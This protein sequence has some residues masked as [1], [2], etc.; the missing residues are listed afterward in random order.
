MA[1]AVS[2]E[3]LLSVL[4]CLSDSELLTRKSY[5][6]RLGA[7]IQIYFEYASCAVPMLF[8]E[9]GCMHLISII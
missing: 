8:T 2:P 3:D 4:T 1:A 9:S 6:L 7:R 5:V